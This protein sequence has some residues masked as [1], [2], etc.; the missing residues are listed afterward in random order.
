MM[1][2]SNSRC[3]AFQSA[4]G[5][6]LQSC[7][8]PET[9]REL[10]AHM[11]VSVATTTINSAIRSLSKQANVAIRH[12]GQSLLTSYAYDNLD[13]DLKHSVPTAEKPQDTLVHLST[14]TMLPLHPSVKLES[15]SYSNELWEKSRYNL[16][17][18]LQDTPSVTFDQLYS[19]YPEKP[20]SSTLTRRQR[21]GA[22]KY[23]ADLLEFGPTYFRKFKQEFSKCSPEAI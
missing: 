5:V 9:L 2:S 21:F 19:I 11:G 1:H 6:F 10:L 7:N 16:N 17:A 3:N 15:L 12:L 23:L 14:M 4:V 18:R 13:I 8:A 20:H 22:W